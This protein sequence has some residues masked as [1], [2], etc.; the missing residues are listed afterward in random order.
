MPP[1]PSQKT[2]VTKPP[3]E[4]PETVTEEKDVQIDQPVKKNVCFE[5]WEEK[6]KDGS[7]KIA[8]VNDCNVK[9]GGRTNK[10]RRRNKRS[11]KTRKSK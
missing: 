2:S 5:V 6:G 11:R 7:F 4:K 8:L 3:Q 9:K 10:R 1:K